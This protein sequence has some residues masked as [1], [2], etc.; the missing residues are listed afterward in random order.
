LMEGQNV[1]RQLKER[2]HDEVITVRTLNEFMGGI[3]PVDWTVTEYVG[4]MR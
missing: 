4:L 1:V 3:D 2:F